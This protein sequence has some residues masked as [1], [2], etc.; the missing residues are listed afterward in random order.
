MWANWL[1]YAVRYDAPHQH[2]NWL[3][4]YSD[5]G[6]SIC[7]KEIFSRQTVIDVIERGATFCT[8]FQNPMG[9]WDFGAMLRVVDV[10]GT[11]YLTTGAGP[12]PDDNLGGVPEV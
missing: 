12:S 6:D 5:D 8:I 9:T 11:K 10:D 1:I 2:I 4:A 3:F 7:R